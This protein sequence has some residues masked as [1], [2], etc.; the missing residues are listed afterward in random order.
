MS[1]ELVL[2]VIALV[3]LV[4]SIAGKVPLWPSVLMLILIHIIKLYGNR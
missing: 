4:I 2:L 1:V 3:L